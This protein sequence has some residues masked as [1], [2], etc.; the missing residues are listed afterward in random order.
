MIDNCNIFYGRWM[1][2]DF[3]VFFSKIIDS[4]NV[5][6]QEMDIKTKSLTTQPVSQSDNNM[7]E[8]VIGN[9]TLIDGKKNVIAKIVKFYILKKIL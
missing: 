9:N 5:N 2:L 8:F 3:N 6:T 4:S 1:Y 7:T